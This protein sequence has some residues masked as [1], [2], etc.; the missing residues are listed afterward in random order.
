MLGKSIDQM[1]DE[2]IGDILEDIQ[3]AMVDRG[4]GDEMR[5]RILLHCLASELTE[6]KMSL[7]N[8]LGDLLA[9]TQMVAGAIIQADHDHEAAWNK[10]KPH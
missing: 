2:D 3:D 9:Y 4:V 6:N 10:R 7:Q 8:A 1:S 5:V